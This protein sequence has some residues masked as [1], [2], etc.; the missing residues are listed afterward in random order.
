MWELYDKGDLKGFFASYLGQFCLLNQTP[1]KL[2]TTLAIWLISKSFID[3]F[4]SVFL[5]ENPYFTLL[6][7]FLRSLEVLN[8]IVQISCFKIKHLLKQSCSILKWFVIFIFD[9]KSLAGM[10]HSPFVPWAYFLTSQTP[11]L[12][13]RHVYGV[14]IVT[15]KTADF[16]GFLTSFLLPQS[17]HTIQNLEKCFHNYAFKYRMI[18]LHKL[19]IFHHFPPLH[20]EYKRHN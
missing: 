3:H 15:H 9:Q 1:S 13:N 19:F 14:L 20:S 4:Y 8:S 16:D 17:F 11:K 12:L 6:S 5:I 10:I 2:K 18:F 7:V